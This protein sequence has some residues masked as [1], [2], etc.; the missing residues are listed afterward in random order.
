MSGFGWCCFPSYLFFYGGLSWTIATKIVKWLKTQC[1]QIVRYESSLFSCGHG[2][3]LFC[4]NVCGINSVTWY[5]WLLNFNRSPA[6]DIH[7]CCGFIWQWL[8]MYSDYTAQWSCWKTGQSYQYWKRTKVSLLLHIHESIPRIN[9]T[10]HLCILA[11]KPNLC[12]F[13][14]LRLCI[15]VM[16]DFY[17]ACIS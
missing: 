9:P 2:W 3:R 7:T 4:N 17:F 11:H 15:T 1:N 8:S 10:V 12:A 14:R 13:D 6:L 5:W 16:C